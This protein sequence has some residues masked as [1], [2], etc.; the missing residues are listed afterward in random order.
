VQKDINLSIL[1]HKEDK[2]M[3]KLFY[4]KIQ[5][6]NTK[7]D[8]I[9]NSNSKDNL[10]EYDLTNKLTL[11][12]HDHPYIYPLGWVNEVHDYP[13]LYPLGW[14]NKDAEI[15]VTKQCKIKFA[16]SANFINEVE[17]DVVPLD[18]CGVLFGSPYMYLR[19]VI[20]TRRSNQYHLIKDGN[21]FIMIQCIQMQIKYLYVSVNQAKMLINYSKM[22][23][24]IFLK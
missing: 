9:F 13:Y 4:I 11:E 14:V 19:N 6:K 22:Y 15:R 23:V 8:V 20:F 10:I 3:T 17:L 18:M 1:H 2:E 7:M 16:I 12:V 21:T 24:F 5:I